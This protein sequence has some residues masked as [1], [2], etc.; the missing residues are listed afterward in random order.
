MA[1]VDGVRAAGIDGS[2][3]IAAGT[4]ALDA[5][6]FLVE[7]IRE[8]ITLGKN[9]RLSFPHRLGENLFRHSVHRI[10]GQRAKRCGIVDRG[11]NGI[12]GKTGGSRVGRHHVFNRF[13]I[14]N[15]F[16]C[17]IEKAV[18]AHGAQFVLD[19]HLV[20]DLEVEGDLAVGF[21]RTA[22]DVVDRKSVLL[23]DVVIE[24]EGILEQGVH[25]LDTAVGGSTRRD[26]SVAVLL[27]ITGGL[28]VIGLGVGIVLLEADLTA[29]F[30]VRAAHVEHEMI[31]NED[32]DV[33]VA[34][35]G[36]LDIIFIFRLM[37][38]GIYHNVAV[39]IALE[40]LAG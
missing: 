24:M 18:D 12:G 9:Y 29:D 17:I 25:V 28:D 3:F 40:G 33:I 23:G 37:C 22:L 32:P 15:G 27:V 2:V 34:A 20:G 39:G 6:V 13:G 10:K 38:C 36:E 11:F 26:G 1:A 7:F 31:V 8:I 21:Q 35:E 4:P 5:V 30:A 14:G 16:Q 19:R